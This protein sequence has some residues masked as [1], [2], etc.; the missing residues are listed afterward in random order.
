MTP[1]TRAYIQGHAHA[2]ATALAIIETIEPHILSTLP[3]NRY[4]PGLTLVQRL[5][6]PYTLDEYR[7]AKV[8]DLTFDIIEKFTRLI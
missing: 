3:W 2:V 7:K 5:M 8:S 6:M 1:E 4:E